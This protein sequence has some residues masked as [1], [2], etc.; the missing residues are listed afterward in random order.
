MV[1]AFT[2]LCYRLVQQAP[3]R[4]F[5]STST[6][7]LRDDEDHDDDDAAVSSSRVQSTP[8]PRSGYVEQSAVA[9]AS[10]A[11][12]RS[13]SS[14]SISTVPTN[15]AATAT[16]LKADRRC[17]PWSPDELKERCAG[18]LGSLAQAGLLAQEKVMLLQCILKITFG[19]CSVHAPPGPSWLPFAVRRGAAPTAV[20]DSDRVL[21]KSASKDGSKSSDSLVA[22]PA[23]IDEK[24]SSPNVSPRMTDGSVVKSSS[25]GWIRDSSTLS[26]ADVVH[27]LRATPLLD[28]PMDPSD[29]VKQARAARFAEVEQVCKPSRAAYSALKLADDAADLPGLEYCSIIKVQHHLF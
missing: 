11:T 16:D 24:K 23:G 2:E 20:S 17:S 15:A 7:W 29:A 12:D 26:N 25:S 4:P 27:A 3:V 5:K 1:A 13:T 19:A 8:M 28:T 14:T 6:A 10:P 18:P 21:Q 22:L 9:A